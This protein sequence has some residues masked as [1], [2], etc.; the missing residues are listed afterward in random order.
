MLLV[1]ICTFYFTKVK[2]YIAS[3]DS[4]EYR[5]KAWSKLIE[6][7]SVCRYAR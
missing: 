7:Q 6:S 1:A 5:N 4:R 2:G 3:S